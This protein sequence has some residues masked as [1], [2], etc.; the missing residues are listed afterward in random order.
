MDQPSKPTGNP[1]DYRCPT[2]GLT[3]GRRCI[4]ARDRPHKLRTDVAEGRRAP[5]ADGAPDNLSWLRRAI[6]S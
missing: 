3:P 6:T 1:L 5:V 4:T 2:C